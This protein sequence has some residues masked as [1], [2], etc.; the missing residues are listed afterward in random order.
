MYRR[1][2]CTHH[3]LYIDDVVRMRHSHKFDEIEVVAELWW[4]VYTID[5]LDIYK[6][7]RFLE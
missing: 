2:C 5:M 4:T 6:V 1:A 7:E 3:T